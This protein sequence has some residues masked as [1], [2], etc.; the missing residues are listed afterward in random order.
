MNHELLSGEELLARL[1]DAPLRFKWKNEHNES[2]KLFL[3]AQDSPEV[4]A[5]LKEL[6]ATSCQTP[7]DVKNLNNHMV[8]VFKN[9]AETALPKRQGQSSHSNKKHRSKKRGTRMKPKK[10]WFDKHCINA[11]R[12][13]NCLAKRY[14]KN[15]GS[16]DLRSDYYKKRREY[17]KLVKSKE[18]KFIYDLSQDIA[19]GNN[20]NWGR[21]KK[22]KRLK[23]CSSQLDAF[24]MYNFCSFFK[25][26]Y[27]EPT[28]PPERITS[29]RIDGKN[30]D[31]DI[32]HETLDKEIS[33]EELGTAINQLKLGKAV[34]ED[35]I[36]NEFLKSSRA[37]IL[38]SPSFT[39]SMN[40]YV[41]GPIRGTHRW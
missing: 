24:D 16:Q 1:D 13:L 20:I 38:K 9:I 14:G 30:I 5:K 39:F 34:A 26:L 19:A 33:L 41:W 10:P 15:P 11:K 31:V 18:D 12:E 29:L 23:E 28:L 25:R 17:K 3:E 21:F 36:A 27:K 22:L 35:V 37:P 40:A 32:L 8:D 2:E 6:Q 4:C 7:E